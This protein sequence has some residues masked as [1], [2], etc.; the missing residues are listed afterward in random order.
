MKERRISLDHEVSAGQPLPGGENHSLWVQ[1]RP[2]RLIFLLALASGIIKKEVG[3]YCDIHPDGEGQRKRYMGYRRDEAYAAFSQEGA[4]KE[5]VSRAVVSYLEQ[6]G[7][8]EAS[9]LKQYSEQLER[10]LSDDPHLPQ[11]LRSVINEEL[12]LIKTHLSSSQ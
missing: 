3:Y 2:L 11:D 5:N 7:L 8:N 4:M 12:S 6:E 1:E 10:V 9:L